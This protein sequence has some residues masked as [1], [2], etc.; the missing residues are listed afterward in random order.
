MRCLTAM[1][2]TM[3][4][5]PAIGICGDGSAI[6]PDGPT[7]RV[8]S[9]TFAGDEV[10]P[11][12]RRLVLFDAGVIYEM[13]LDDDRVATIYDPGRGR[14]L[15]I[16]RE[17]LQVAEIATS[18]L[19]TVAAQV[20]AQVEQE[21]RGED[22]GLDAEVTVRAPESPEDSRRFVIAFG[23][24]RYETTTRKVDD[25]QLAEAYYKYSQLAA[26][27]NIFR[28][29]GPPPFARLNLIK[30][31]TSQGQLPLS[32]T[33][34]VSRGGGLKKLRLRAQMEVI[35][36]LSKIDRERIAK[37]GETLARCETISIEQFQQ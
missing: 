15:L 12:S 7:F 29:S 21:D 37:L 4:T 8:E 14:V 22:F 32:T 31:V 16:D 27:L 34:E 18:R 17:H 3:F 20:R 13:W 30:H 19:L 2:I 36:Q 28:R 10:Q 23:D 1:L 11:A 9:E 26:Q 25:R 5:T 24:T 33:L 6:V 35:G